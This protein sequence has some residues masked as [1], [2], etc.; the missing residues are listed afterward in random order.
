VLELRDGVEAELIDGRPVVPLDET[1][2]F[3]NEHYATFQ[4]ALDML[5]RMYEEIDVA[6]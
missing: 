6:Q 4:S 5:D 2:E 1:I 3:A